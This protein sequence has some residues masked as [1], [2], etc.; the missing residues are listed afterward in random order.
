M[1][2]LIHLFLLCSF[3]LS[4][5]VHIWVSSIENDKIEISIKNNANIFGFDFKIKTDDESPLNIDYSEE[6]FTNGSISESLYT[7]DSGLGTVSQNDFTCFTDG[8]N[9]F[10]SL[11]LGNNFLPVSDSTIMMTIPL[12]PNQN[13]SNYS[14]E[15]PIFLSKDIDY[16]LIDLEVEYGLIEYQA[17]WPFTDSAKILGAPAIVD[18][19][20]DGLNEVIFCDYFGRIF[21]TNYMGELLHSFETGGQIWGSPAVAD[22]N[23]DGSLEIIVSSKDKHLYI[24]NNQA[25]LINSYNT[26]QYLLG[27]PAI[28]NLD[29]DSDLEIVVGGYSSE[30]KIFVINMDGTDV[31]GFPILI[32]EKIQRGVALA[33]LNQNNLD[34]IIFGTDSERVYQVY[35]DGTIAVSTELEGDI[36]NAPSII[37]MNNEHLIIVGSRDDNLYGITESGDI[38]FSYNTGNKVD[39]SPIAIEYNEQVII[40]FGSSDGYLYAIDTNGQD[41]SGFPINIGNGI[42]SSPVVA[43]FNGDGLPEI[44]VS[45]V[46]NDLHIYDLNGISYTVIP[47]TFEFP[48]SGN[49]IIDDIDIDGDLEILVGATNGMVAV[50][51]KDINGQTEN[52]WHKFRNNLHRTGYIESSQELDIKNPEMLNDF[53]LF[54]PYPNPFNPSTTIHYYI[55]EYS[56]VEVVV[57]DIMGKKLDVLKSD[58]LKPGDYSIEWDASSFA[59]G[60][61]FIYLNSDNVKLSKSITLIK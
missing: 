5:D 17:G 56:Y 39:S 47:I 11:S 42:E 7:I 15:S 3:I 29:I 2:F 40:L 32:N 49:P 43:D 20:E 41:I 58:F 60:K 6:S 55:P 18:I 4:D 24:L 1:H 23:N 8:D 10:I 46:S 26:D 48:F 57:H 59:S 27:T 50:D 19:N 38:K 35:D 54:N 61:Y 52:Y 21:I 33:D 28:G 31:E 30:G 9:R 12:I 51:I 44:V 13:S 34:D 22:L 16:S 53:S 45:S 14:I 25:E 36:R 37:K